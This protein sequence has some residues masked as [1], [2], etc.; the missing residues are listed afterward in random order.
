MTIK[1]IAAD[2]HPIVTVGIE[3]V[4]GRYENVELIGT[5]SDSEQVL[6][7][8]GTKVCDVLVTDPYAIQIK[9]ESCRSVIPVIQD[10]NPGLR[11]VAHACIENPAQLA[12]MT[13][14]GIAAVLHRFDTVSHLADAI[15]AAHFNARY[16]SPS[17]LRKNTN[18]SRLNDPDRALTPRESEILAL[19]VSGK[20]VCE[21]ARSLHR[22]KQTISAHK[23]RAM[24]KLGICN[25]AELFRL[26]FQDGFLSFCLSCQAG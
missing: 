3:Q 25:D 5:A 26:A 2:S 20:T 14:L 12:T 10:R 17:L 6:R 15:K 19:F 9:S 7:L 23:M 4:L 24:V 1:V 18:I 13:R 8:V 22:S 21:I 16:F 11:I